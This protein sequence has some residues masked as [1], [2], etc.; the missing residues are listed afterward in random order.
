MVQF[1][2]PADLANGR[3]IASNLMLSHQFDNGLVLVAEPMQ[4][5]ESAAFTFLLPVGAMRDPEKSLG[6]SNYTCEMV[7]RGCGSRDSRQ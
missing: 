4:W 3:I 1:V 7:Q 2:G 6:L 5:L